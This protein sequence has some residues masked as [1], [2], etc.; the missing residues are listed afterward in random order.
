[1]SKKPKGC[2]GVKMVRA[3]QKSFLRFVDRTSVSI[4]I[5]DCDVKLY[6][7]KFRIPFPNSSSRGRDIWVLAFSIAYTQVESR[8]NVN[9]PLDGRFF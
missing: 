9:R 3:Y 4:T 7:K 6:M 1:M 2:V 5:E 8:K